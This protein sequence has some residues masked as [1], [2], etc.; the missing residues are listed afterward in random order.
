[1][2]MLGTFSCIQMCTTKCSHQIHV[3]CEYVCLFLA[4]KIEKQQ[5]DKEM[6]YKKKDEKKI[7][8][9]RPLN[10]RSRSFIVTQTILQTAY[11]TYIYANFTVREQ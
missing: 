3:V 1:M 10:L 11:I 4:T 9:L 8:V 6:N 7:Y 5:T 2:S